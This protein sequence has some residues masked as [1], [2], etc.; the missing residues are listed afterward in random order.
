MLARD[1]NNKGY[2]MAEFACEGCGF[3]KRVGDELAGKRGKCPKCGGTGPVFPDAP[4]Q[5][6]V[7][8]ERSTVSRP[9]NAQRR[10]PAKLA[11]IFATIFWLVAAVGLSALGT[12]GSYASGHHGE[13]HVLNA[14]MTQSFTKSEWLV[15]GA[16]HATYSACFLCVVLYFVTIGVCLVFYFATS[17]DRRSMTSPTVQG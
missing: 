2:A 15:R 14:S 5:A 4:V 11:M 12:Y 10:H 16:I 6:V 13:T 1:F 17:D 9:V 7:V 8:P 3:T